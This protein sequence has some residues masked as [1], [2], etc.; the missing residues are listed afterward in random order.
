MLPF[1]FLLAVAAPAR[2]EKQEAAYHAEAAAAR[3]ITE[4]QTREAIDAIDR[5]GLPAG[6][7]TALDAALV[8]RSLVISAGDGFVPQGLTAEELRNE[9]V[10][11][12][13]VSRLFWSAFGSED[14]ITT[15]RGVSGNAW[16][17]SRNVALFGGVVLPA[18]STTLA[19][20]K[21]GDILG[22]RYALS[23]YNNR[24]K[25]VD[26]T[27]L[28]LVVAVTQKD[29][30]LIVHSWNP[31][32]ELFPAGTLKPW[33]LRIEFLDD[34][35][36]DFSGLFTVMEIIK[37]RDTGKPTESTEGGDFE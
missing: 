11:A 37:P 34:L 4:E 29:G 33:P 36:S 17:M 10:C 24:P 31:P 3:R 22:I 9:A 23:I 12:K 1:L 5:A 15:A 25:P 18:N 30:P 26:Y 35:L 8:L 6:G 14:D 27:H 20:L 2:A 32:M 28:A 7:G 16:D 21:A 13:V 19:S